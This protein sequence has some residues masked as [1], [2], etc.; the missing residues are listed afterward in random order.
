MGHFRFKISRGP[1][2][3]HISTPKWFYGPTQNKTRC[4]RINKSLKF[5]M[6]SSKISFNSLRKQ[7]LNLRWER[8]LFERLTGW[9][10]ESLYWVETAILN[11]KEF[12]L[13][14]RDER[15]VRLGF[16]IDLW[17]ERF[18]FTFSNKLDGA[19]QIQDFTGTTGQTY[20]HTKVILWTYSEQDALSS[21]Q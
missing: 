15:E 14:L 21:N 11:Q 20:F 5:E 2:A 12:I 10:E 16:L 13:I 17:L 4:R 3:R 6:I 19:F 1:L 9:Y 7:K 8:I 18:F